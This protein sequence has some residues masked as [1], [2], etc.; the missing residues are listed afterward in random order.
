MSLT[1]VFPKTLLGIVVLI[2]TLIFSSVGHADDNIS[3]ENVE[4]IFETTLGNFT[5]SLNQEKAPITVDNVLQYVNAG[6]YD[7]TI[8]HRVIGN[9]MIQGGGFD[10]NMVK[11]DTHAAISNEADNRLKNEVGTIAMARTNAPHSATA[12]FFINVENNKSLNHTG[13]NSR[14]WGYAVFGK[15]TDGIDVINAIKIVPTTS[16]GGH[17]NVPV[18]PVIILKAYVTAPE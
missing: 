1:S 7:G 14:G 15:V 4:V 6:Y 10:K 3:N 2:V 8:F 16:K 9:F 17:Q 12:Q 11:K 5:L 13:K 18:E